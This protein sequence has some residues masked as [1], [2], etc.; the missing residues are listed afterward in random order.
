MYIFKNTGH[1]NL[2]QHT[3]FLLYELRNELEFLFTQ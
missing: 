2:G 3:L 1:L